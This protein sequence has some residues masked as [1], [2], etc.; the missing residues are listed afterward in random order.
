MITGDGKAT[1]LT[2]TKPQLPIDRFDSARILMSMNKIE[3]FNL[4][5]IG[6]LINLITVNEPHSKFL[7]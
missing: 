3:F 5:R 7:T 6:T 4:I 2:A 1:T